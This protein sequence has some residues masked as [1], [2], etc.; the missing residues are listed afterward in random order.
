MHS[1]SKCMTKFMSE[2]TPT[3][4]VPCKQTGHQFQKTE[5]H[6]FLHNLSTDRTKMQPYCQSGLQMQFSSAL[7]PPPPYLIS[8][9]IS[10]MFLTLKSFKFLVITQQLTSS[11]SLSTASWKAKVIEVRSPLRNGF[12]LSPSLLSM[13]VSPRV[14]S[15]E[16][17]I[18]S[19]KFHSLVLENEMKFNNAIPYLNRT[20]VPSYPAL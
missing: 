12:F 11:G 5:H 19:T 15:D 1:I 7:E 10:G 9:R 8:I 6:N 18:L 4:P 3:V 16:L 20:H 14:T 13:K 17:K 2:E